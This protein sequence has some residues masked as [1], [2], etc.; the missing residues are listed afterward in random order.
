MTTITIPKRLAGKDDLVV[1]PKKEFDALVARAEA[2]SE[3]TVTEK[4]ILRWGREAKKLYKAGKL[5]KL[6]LHDL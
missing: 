6:N 5:P 4:N 3:E 2:A 1:V